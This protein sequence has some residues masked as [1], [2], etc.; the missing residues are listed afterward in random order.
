MAEIQHIIAGAGSEHALREPSWATDQ[1]QPPADLA[2][3][4]QRAIDMF[5]LSKQP[6]GEMGGI[7]WWQTAN[8][9]TAVALHDLWTGSRHNYQILAEML[10]QCER[11][12]ANFINEFNDDSLWWALCCIHLY[13][14]GRDVWFLEKAKSVWH[15]IRKSNS[16]C[17][18]GRVSFNG[19]DMEGACFWTTK[20]GEEQ[21][22]SISTGL[23]AELSVRLALIELDASRQTTKPSHLRRLFGHTHASY[24]DYIEAARRSLG[25]ILRC[26]YRTDDAVVLDNI[27]VRQ[28]I[29]QDWAFTYTTGVTLGVCALLY[30]AT[31]E[32]NYMRIACTMARH[33]MQRRDWVEEN[34]VLTE[35]GAYGRGKD[36]PYEHPDGV[37][38]KS[39]LVRH[40]STLYQVIR[41]GPA[42][43]RDAADT[44]AL[45]KSFVIVNFR[46]QIERNTNGNNQFGPWWNGPFECPTSHS[47]MAVLDVMAAIRLVAN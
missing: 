5:M 21:I 11:T 41:K 16:I 6:N 33:S 15:H 26:R 34:G 37:G 28:Q 32:D 14:I 20:P 38:F 29:A 23:F 19:R 39:V 9:Y 45:I 43:S 7:G 10:K 44:A 36:N 24:D 18:R 27:L 4:T 40:L 46:S 35:S 17:G 3:I 2:G 30:E 12:H 1:L 8:G 22:N 47:Q 42:H 31:K 25:W 13:S